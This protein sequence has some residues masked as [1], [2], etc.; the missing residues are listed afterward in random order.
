ME[1]FFAFEKELHLARGLF[2]TLNA[3]IG[4]P[5]FSK[6]SAKAFRGY[7]LASLE[8]LAERGRIGGGV[9][10]RCEFLEVGR[11]DI[12]EVGLD[13]SKGPKISSLL[14]TTGSALD[15]ASPDPR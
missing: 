9:W 2:V 3:V 4:S 1:I 13:P 14:C 5:H 6:G 10:V 11:H 8:V 12:A 15:R 7:E